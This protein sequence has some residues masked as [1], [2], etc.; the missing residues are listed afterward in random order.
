MRTTAASLLIL[1]A[2]IGAATAL[3]HEPRPLGDSG[4]QISVG[5]RNEPA[6]EDQLNAVDVFVRRADGSGVSGADNVVDLRVEVQLR[7]TDQFEAASVASAQLGVPRLAFGTTDR[8]NTSFKPT[9]DGAYAFRVRG[10]IHDVTG[11][12]EP[13]EIDETFVCGA[14]TRDARAR[15]FGCVEDPIAFPSYSLERKLGRDISGYL[16]NDEFSKE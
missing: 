13:V 14:G 1:S 9:A 6:F 12:R 16:D 11:G 15:N 2:M 10:T 3:A 5:F 7:T 8:Y 4:L